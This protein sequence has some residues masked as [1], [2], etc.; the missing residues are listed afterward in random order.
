MR[1][2]W[3]GDTWVFRR[4]ARIRLPRERVIAHTPDGIPYARPEVAVLYKAKNARPKDDSDF[5]RVLS[6]LDPA[7]RRWLA[8]S[9]E[10]VHPGHR[11]LETLST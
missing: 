2:P 1:E 7:G 8:Q 4:D 11:W 10:L 9:L 6:L 5:A 3:E